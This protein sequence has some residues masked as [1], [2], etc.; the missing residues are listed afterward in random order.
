MQN[1]TELMPVSSSE[2]NVV[3][4]STSPKKTMA[5]V[6]GVIYSVRIL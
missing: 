4:A 2:M 3:D 5:T 1:A 6:K